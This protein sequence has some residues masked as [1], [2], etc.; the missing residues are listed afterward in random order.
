[1]AIKTIW[2]PF[3]DYL[4]I[5]SALNNVN[6]TKKF[7]RYVIYVLGIY[8]FQQQFENKTTLKAALSFCMI[9]YFLRNSSC[10]TISFSYL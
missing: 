4:K 1:M 3:L 10:P 9:I 2:R 7:V 5:H 8:L 6:E